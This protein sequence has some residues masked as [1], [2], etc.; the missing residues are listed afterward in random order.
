MKKT[1]KI[2]NRQNKLYCI[3]QKFFF[4]LFIISEQFF[5]KTHYNYFKFS[6]EG[7]ECVVKGNSPLTPHLGASR[8]MTRP[9]YIY[10][11]ME[12]IRQSVKKRPSVNKLSISILLPEL[13]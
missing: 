12:Y 6:L 8:S 9:D 11:E 3:K 1:S 4:L 10:S 13:L 2:W 5:C 7:V